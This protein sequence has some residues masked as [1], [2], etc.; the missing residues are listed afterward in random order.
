MRLFSLHRHIGGLDM[1]HLAAYLQLNEG[2]LHVEH[3]VV[4]NLL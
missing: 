4:V 2:D 1:L 3:Y